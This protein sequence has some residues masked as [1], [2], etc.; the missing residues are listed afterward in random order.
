MS[1]LMMLRR[2]RHPQLTL[3][4]LDILD[5]ARIH[6]AWLRFVHDRNRRV[7]L[8]LTRRS[9]WAILLRLWCARSSPR[10]CTQL[11]RVCGEIRKYRLE[12]ALQLCRLLWNIGIRSVTVRIALECQPCCYPPL[13]HNTTYLLLS[14][15]GLILLVCKWLPATALV[16]LSTF[17]LVKFAYW[18]PC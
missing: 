8:Q 1:S 6:A 14:R 10:F 12:Y 15:W 11:R 3:L 9:A 16:R 18:K 13:D 4:S 2:V 5:N 17:T 7:K